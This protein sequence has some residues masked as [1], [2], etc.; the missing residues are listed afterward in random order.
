MSNI[1]LDRSI[2]ELS[3]MPLIMGIGVY[4]YIYIYITIAMLHRATKVWD[5]NFT[6]LPSPWASSHEMIIT[7]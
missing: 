6:I 4:I 2:S 3:F 1:N 7:T 5:L